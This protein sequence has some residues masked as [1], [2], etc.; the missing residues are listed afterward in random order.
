[1]ARSVEEP[2]SAELA[3]EL[4]TLDA[5][6]SV[7]LE[8]C[9]LPS[10]EVLSD[11]RICPD[12]FYT[13]GNLGKS[14]NELDLVPHRVTATGAGSFVGVIAADNEDD[15]RPGYDYMSKPVL[16]ARLST[17]ICSISSSD[18]KY[19]TPGIG[20]T[21]VTLYRDVTLENTGA[22]DTVCV[23][24]Y[25]VRLALGSHLFPGASLHSNLAN[26]DLSPGGVGARDVSIPV[27]GYPATGARQV[28]DRHTSA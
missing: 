15:S 27:N 2:V 6:A 22:K 1:M 21:Y 5:D 7:T 25:Y 8:G 12:G 18:Q 20:G 10:G 13:K 3:A 17:G 16:N 23:S 11:P 14:W 28:D 9:R 19:A 24:D 26:P 4:T